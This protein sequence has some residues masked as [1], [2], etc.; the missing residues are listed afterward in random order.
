MENKST[1]VTI[2]DKQECVSKKLLLVEDY[3]AAVRK[4]TAM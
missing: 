3:V 4:P 2:H 1:V